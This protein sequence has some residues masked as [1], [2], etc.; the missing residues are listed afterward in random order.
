MSPVTPLIAGASLK[1]VRGRT[2]I[3]DV[4]HLEVRE[5]E[6][7][8]LI[9]PNGAGKTSL[10][11]T[12][13]YLATPFSGDVFFTGRRV[14]AD[15]PVLE[16]RRAVAMAFQ[17]PLLFDTSVAENVASGLRIR[18][19]RKSAILETVAEYLDLFGISHLGGRSAR[20][21]S[22]GEAQRTNLAR[23]FAT[24][25][26]V[27]FLDEPF[28][29]LD[30]GSREPLID[31][32]QRVL[33]KTK[34]TAFIVTHDLMEA[35]RLSD[36]IAVMGRGRIHQIG[37]PDEVMNTPVDEAVASFVGAGTVLTGR[38][39]EN[40]T[41]TFLA[42]I[43]GHEIE[44]AGDLRA[45]DPVSL[46]IRP[47]N[48]TLSVSSGDDGRKRSTSAR[49]VFPAKVVRITP[50]GFFEKV[51]LDCGFPLTAYVTRQSREE[52]GLREGQPAIASFKAT[53]I[54]VIP[55]A[56]ATRRSLP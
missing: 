18:S 15:C 29:S 35:L 7:L 16:Y 40:R 52:L 31:D 53:A 9:G 27:I 34:T 22:G 11:Q 14:G 26:R 44:S 24:K 8:S 41:D 6:V 45:G 39:T 49:N 25:P 5:G 28:A 32:I 21:L 38:V 43:G 13:A 19:L 33:E 37:T 20:T 42:A 50:L 48:V 54:H 12:L 46:Y 1:M 30:P 55:C 36:R 47:E 56:T 51:L 17:E 10:L 23:A 4:P 2:T 3:L